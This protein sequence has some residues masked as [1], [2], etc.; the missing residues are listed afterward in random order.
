MSCR[1][2]EDSVQNAAELTGIGAHRYAPRHTDDVF[3]PSSKA[4]LTRH[5]VGRFPDQTLLHRVGRAVCEAGC[6]P[7]KEFYEAWEVA[8]RVRRRFRGGRIVD[9]CAGHGLLGQLMLLLDD[10]SASVVIVDRTIPLSATTLHEALVREW[11]R[12]DGRV[13]FHESDVDALPLSPADVVVS[14]H[15]CGALTDA[16]LRRATV[17]GARVAVMPCCH[18]LDRSDDGRL[19]GWMTGALAVDAVRATRLVAHGWQVWTQTIPGEITPHNRLLMA[20]PTRPA[21]GRA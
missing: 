19:A 11:P 7:R 14:V 1:R 18:D 4:R 8:R 17:A 6:L 3:S 15:A 5:D 9:L 21:A 16:V 2:S 10:T 13:V 12:L 20:A